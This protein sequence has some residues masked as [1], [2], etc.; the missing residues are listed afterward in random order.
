MIGRL[1][2][3][4]GNASDLSLFGPQVGSQ[5]EL[6]RCKRTGIKR[7]CKKRTP[8]GG[9]SDPKGL[10]IALFQHQAGTTAAISPLLTGNSSILS[11]VYSHFWLSLTIAPIIQHRI[12]MNA[13]DV[14][15]RNTVTLSFTLVAV[16]S[17]FYINQTKA[18]D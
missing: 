1:S 12:I 6:R 4:G 3:C 18:N 16:S 8:R 17:C 5:I 2:D 13:S 11:C 14:Y 15:S 10:K 9:E 7:L